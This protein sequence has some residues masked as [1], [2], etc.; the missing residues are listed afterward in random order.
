MGKKSKRNILSYKRKK[1]KRNHINRRKRNKTKRKTQIGGDEDQIPPSEVVPF[2]QAA[3][4]QVEENMEARLFALKGGL[5][6]DIQANKE[7]FIRLNNLYSSLYLDQDMIKR[8][9]KTE[10]S[11]NW[12]QLGKWTGVSIND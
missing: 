10:L 5:E 12:R 4:K 7:R 8:I 1:T 2:L 3:I 6:G 9:L 11:V